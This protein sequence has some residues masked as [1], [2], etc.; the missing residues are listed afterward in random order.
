MRR[1]V[2]AFFFNLLF[3]AMGILGGNVWVVGFL[4]VLLAIE[5]AVLER[6]AYHQRELICEVHAE[7][8]A[9]GQP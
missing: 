7:L 4:A 6:L 8:T 9:W 2:L 1:V 3:I 5:V